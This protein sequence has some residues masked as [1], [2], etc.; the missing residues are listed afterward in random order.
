MPISTGKACSICGFDNCETVQSTFAKNESTAAID[1]TEQIQAAASFFAKSKSTLIGGLEWLP[2]NAQMVAWRIA[3]QAR[4]IIDTS[5]ADHGRAALQTLQ[6]HGKVSA[7]YGEIANRSDLIVFWD[8]DL[9][10]KPCLLKMLT[11]KPVA[12]RKIVLVGA[13]DSLMASQADYVFPV[14]AGCDSNAMVRLISRLRTMTTQQERVDDRYQDRDLPLAKVRQLYELL[15]G[16]SYGSL[17]F[18]SHETDWEFDL[19]TESLMRFVSEFNSIAP[20]VGMNVRDNGNGLGAETVLTLASGFPTAI[21]L[22]R[23][24]A[25]SNGRIYSA[26]EVMRRSACDTILLFGNVDQIGNVAPNVTPNGSESIPSWLQTELDRLT[27][28]QLADRPASFADV[29]IAC[30]LIEPGGAFVGEVLRG[31]GVMLTGACP[32]RGRSAESILE[33]FADAVQAATS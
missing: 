7:T 13:A 1:Q 8:C 27:V 10:R 30:P 11:A 20:L 5:V 9:Q 2:M 14:N 6:R 12:D 19:A 15:A 32:V 28:I 23:G 24:H 18:G 21:S 16:A 4:S 3:D 29:F 22:Q 26:A 17:F 33:S 25:E 31:D